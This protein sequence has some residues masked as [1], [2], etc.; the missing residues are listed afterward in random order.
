MSS[1]EGECAVIAHGL[2]KPAAWVIVGKMNTTKAAALMGKLGRSANTAAQAEAS[3]RNGQKGGRP[4]KAK[5]QRAAQRKT[6]AA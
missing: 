2:T 4:P 3:R 6:R 5:R 1:T